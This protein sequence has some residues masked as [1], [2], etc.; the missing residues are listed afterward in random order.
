MKALAAAEP[1]PT[2]SCACTTASRAPSTTSCARRSPAP[3]SRCCSCVSRDARRSFPSTIWWRGSASSSGGCRRA[4]PPPQGP[5]RSQCAGGQGLVAP[6]ATESR[7]SASLG[8]RAGSASGQASSAP[9]STGSATSTVRPSTPTVDPSRPRPRARP[10][11]ARRGPHRPSRPSPAARPTPASVPAAHD[12]P[13]P[14][15]AT[16]TRWRLDAWRAVLERI[17]VDRAPL[18]SVLE[19]ASP[20]AFSAERVVLGYEAGLVL[21]GPGDGSFGRRAP[22]AP[23]ARLFRYFDPRSPSTSPPAPSRALDR[24]DRRRAEPRPPR[25]GAA[26]R[27]RASPRARPPSRFWGPSCATSG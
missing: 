22:D 3:R 1:R 19:H 11:I 16:P 8:A 5:S 18:A 2:I 21:G 7:A 15:A 9:S 27:R 13:S 23:R 20:I 6:R 12:T 25:A 4:G 10:P 17:R 26:R 14:L 24:L